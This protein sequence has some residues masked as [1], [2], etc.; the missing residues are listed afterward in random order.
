MIIC[1]CGSLRF[2]DKFEEYE[3]QSV[4]DGN[5]ALLPCC[6]F[7]DIEREYGLGKYKQKADELHK[8]KIDIADEVFV[9]NVD[10][11]IGDSTRSEIHYA[12]GPGKIIKYMIEPSLT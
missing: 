7:V 8:R 2:R 4:L 5:I 1:Y 6:M 9:I 3:Y 12:Q 11:Y 10:G